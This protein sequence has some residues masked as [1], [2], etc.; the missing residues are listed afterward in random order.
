MDVGD[1]DFDL[2]AALIA[3]EPAAER[4]GARLL[5]LERQSGAFTHTFVSALPQLLRAGDLIVVNNTRV[6][7]ARLIG[8]R[9]PSGG[10]VECVLIRSLPGVH[11][12]RT[13]WLP[14]VDQVRIRSRADVDQTGV[15][16]PSDPHPD[17]SLTAESWE[18]L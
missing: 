11:Q 6:F 12:V 4:G 2:P 5:S 18:A 1:F 8:R 17:P 9:V 16:R 3:Q 14:G 15:R 7:P 13:R 10:V